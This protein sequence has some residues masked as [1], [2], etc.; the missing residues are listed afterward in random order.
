MKIK[1][2]RKLTMRNVRSSFAESAYAAASE[3]AGPSSPRRQ[4]GEEDTADYDNDIVDA[5]P[6]VRAEFQPLAGERLLGWNLHA[7]LQLPSL[8]TL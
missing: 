4:E 8:L 2:L 1:R 3:S 7:L 5:R 6:S